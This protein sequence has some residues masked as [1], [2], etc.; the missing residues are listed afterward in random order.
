M[1][2]FVEDIFNTPYILQLGLLTLG[3]SINLLQ[4]CIYK[5]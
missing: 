1:A 4:V 3:M 2:Q 5:K